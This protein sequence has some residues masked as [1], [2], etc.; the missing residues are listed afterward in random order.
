[1]LLAGLSLK[2][3]GPL[4]RLPAMAL[5]AIVGQAILGAKPHPKLA[6]AV[7]IVLSVLCAWW[8]CGAPH[9]AIPPWREGLK[10]LVIAVWFL[11]IVWLALESDPWQTAAAAAALAVSWYAVG[12][13]VGATSPWPMLALVP[14]AAAIG[15]LGQGTKLAFLLPAWIAIA[16]AAA[17]A[18]LAAGRMPHGRF[19]PVEVACLAAPVSFWLAGWIAKKFRRPGA[20]HRALTG[21]LVFG[22]V[23]LLAFSGAALAGLR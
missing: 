9:S 2:F 13:A 10:I 22:L 3:S 19:G 7:A 23:S 8:L 16:A 1:M 18:S 4:S 20:L 12:H 14:A 21:V 5:A 11:A 15:S 6:P 17:A